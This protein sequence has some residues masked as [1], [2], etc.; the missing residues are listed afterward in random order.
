MFLKVR[1]A[2]SAVTSRRIAKLAVSIIVHS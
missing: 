2:F 1:C